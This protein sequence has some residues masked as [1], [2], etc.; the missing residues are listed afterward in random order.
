MRIF[1]LGAI[2]ITAQCF[3]QIPPSGPIT[4][5][6]P[7]GNPVIALS[8]DTPIAKAGQHV[9]FHT[10]ITAATE[11]LAFGF[12]VDA[13]G[14]YDNISAASPTFDVVY[15]QAYSGPVSV[16]VVDL[17][18][19]TSVATIHQ[20]V[21]AQ[22]VESAI[23]DSP[24]A[25]FQLCGSGE[26]EIE[27]GERWAGHAVLTNNGTQPT[28]NGYAV[29][30]QDLSDLQAA[31]IEIETPAV[32]L[33][34]IEPGSSVSVDVPFF[35]SPD[36]M[37]GATVAIRYL[38]TADDNGFTSAQGDA[39]VRAF[40]KQDCQAQTCD[41]DTHSIVFREGNYGD[42]KRPGN[43]V[44]TKITTSSVGNASVFGAW[45]TGDSANEPTWYVFNDAI[46]GN[47]MNAT[48]YSPHQ[49]ATNVFPATKTPVGSAQ[50]TYVAN[51]EVIYTW[52]MGNH[53]GGAKLSHI[54]EDA[55]ST[56]RAWY[57][58]TESGWGTFDE[59]FPN[60]GTNGLPLMFSIAFLYDKN[61]FPTW[62]TSSSDAYQEGSTM[63]A[64]AVHPACPGCI[65]TDE[66]MLEN[67]VG[68]LR[69]Q[70]GAKETMTTNFTLPF[71]LGTWS[72]TNLEVDSL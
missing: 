2:A 22:D 35:V 16:K 12:D 33:P 36:A 40:V 11:P 45:F 1:L 26:N 9:V 3:A 59:I 63:D 4:A 57:N 13:D 23:Q 65:W 27:P 60:A 14:R 18:G 64:Y 8:S 49:Q 43:G 67:Y 30:A 70:P 37:C 38:G 6:P 34:T 53:S 71:Y 20:V 44:T 24:D 61:G 42:P 17:Y 72:R 7:C 55:N 56:L 68:T 69:Y 58:P 31:K 5:Y 46:H 54:V 32:S 66:R 10:S 21:E 62:V 15:P 52:Q 39:V 25:P 19:C 29:F 41:A 47:Q 48:M 28:S 50:L 51:D